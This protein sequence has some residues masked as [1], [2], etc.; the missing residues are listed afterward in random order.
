M[1][2]RNKV[3]S[4]CN[5]AYIAVRKTLIYIE[6][7]VPTNACIVFLI[8]CIFCRF[9]V[10]DMVRYVIWARPP[11]GHWGE[12]RVVRPGDAEWAKGRTAMWGLQQ[13]FPGHQ[14]MIV[15]VC[16]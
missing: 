8:Y 7:S 15:V 4:S 16:L 11:G 13:L 6:Y 14:F 12:C 9:G 10:L 2:A 5:I 3:D 1:P